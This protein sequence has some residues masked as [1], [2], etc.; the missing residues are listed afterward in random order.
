LRAELD[1]IENLLAEGLDEL[2]GIDRSDPADHAGR[3]IFHDPFA[4]R[5]RR[6]SQVPCAE[7]LAMGTVIDPFARGG[8]PFAGGN[9]SGVAE[10]RNQL[11][12]SSRTGS[13]D[14]EV[15]SGLCKVPRSLNPAS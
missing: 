7:L 14:T 2:L 1:D 15:F 3:E 13:Q 4:R 8:D 12:V 6:G 10:H 5:G 11:T 9:C